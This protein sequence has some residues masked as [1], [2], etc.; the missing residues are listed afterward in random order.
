[1][2]QTANAES[3]VYT[4]A[5]KRHNEEM[6]AAAQFNAERRKQIA[7]AA[8]EPNLFC[9]TVDMYVRPATT[10]DLAGIVKIYNYYVNNSILPEDQKDVTEQDMNF[11][12]Q[13]C[14]MNELPFIVAVKGQLPSSTDAQGRKLKKVVAPQ[15][16]TVLGFTFAQI[17]AF[18]FGSA[19]TFKGR[20]RMN[21][22]LHLYV[23][24][25]YQGRGVGRNLL[26][27]LLKILNHA[28]S[29]RDGHDF[30]NPE[31]DK[32][33]GRVPDRWHKV[34]FQVAV[35]SLNHSSISRSPNR[36]KLT[37]RHAG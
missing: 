36:Q 10:K 4:I 14:K 8:P 11:V 25:E 29:F 17:Q 30:I 27:R 21:A 1:M 24:H 26:D 2:N 37:P 28:H 19:N 13:G 9:P 16:E 22:N 23:H 6:K 20:S 33:Y 35:V 32:R 7:M 5:L 18:G 31:N 34:S 15:H 12:L 3:E